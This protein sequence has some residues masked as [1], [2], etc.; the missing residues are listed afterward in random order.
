GRRKFAA[1]GS[2]DRHTTDHYDGWGISGNVKGFFLT[3]RWQPYAVIG[4]G[5]LD[6]RGHHVPRTSQPGDDVDMRFGIGMDGYITEHIAIG[7][8]VA[9]VLPFGDVENFDMVTVALGLRYRF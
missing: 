4:V 8:E 7:P 5:Y 2:P 3:G 1:S 6:I 9:Y